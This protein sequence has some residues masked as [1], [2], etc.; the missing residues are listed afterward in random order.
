MWYSK[1]TSQNDRSS[2]RVP[3]AIVQGAVGMVVC[4]VL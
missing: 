3:D 1:N 2:P 4:V